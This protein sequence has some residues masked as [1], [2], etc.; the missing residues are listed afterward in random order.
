MTNRLAVVALALLL[1]SLGDTAHATGTLSLV[2]DSAGALGIAGG[3]IANLDDASAVRVSPANFADKTQSE[4]LLNAA[5]W[6]GDISFDSANGASLEMDKP[7][8]N[9]G[10]V[11]AIVPV[12]PGR[13]ALGFGISTPNGLAISYPKNSDPRLRYSVAYDA[14]LLQVDFTPAISFKATE[15]LSFGVGLDVIYSDL[16][17]KRVY[18]WGLLT[19]GA[20][21]GEIEFHGD[22]WGLGAYAGVNWSFTKH[23]RLALVGRLPVEVN[24]DGDF[25]ASGL[26]SSLQAAGY[27]KRSDFESDITFPGSISLGYGIDVTDRLTVGFDFQWAANSS[28]DDIPLSVGG[29]QTLLTNDRV[30]LG[31]KNSIDLGTG[32][33]YALNEQWTIR[34]GYLFSENSVGE[35]N[36][37]PSVPSND[38]HVFSLGV[39]WKGKR[40]SIDL[41]YAFVYNPTR[42]ITGAAQPE[43]NGSYDHQWH[44]LSLSVTHR[45]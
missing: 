43:F 17:V 44:V 20:H 41:T 18:P 4:V 25:T 14:R 26:P 13:V 7:W 28:H 24:Y 23:Q 37:I 33:S 32:I 21:D 2:P 3:R 40:N 9:L 22:G 19:S 10:S 11:Y 45:F 35:Y 1:G 16:Q 31:W 27:T 8:V 15:N 36:Y 42:E 29:N 38:R 12:Q 34:G 39:G 5:I 30:D 6:H